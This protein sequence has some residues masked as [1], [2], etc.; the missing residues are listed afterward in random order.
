[1]HS[2]GVNGRSFLC[3]AGK[4]GQWERA[5]QGFC[6]NGRSFLFAA[7]KSGQWESGNPDFGFPLFHGP[8]FFFVFGLSF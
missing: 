8:H 3:A 4:S 5:R 7:G 6:V 2:S 1:V